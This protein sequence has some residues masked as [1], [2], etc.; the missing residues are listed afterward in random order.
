MKKMISTLWLWIAL[1]MTSGC[2]STYW[3]EDKTLVPTEFGTTNEVYSVHVGQKAFWIKS[4][5]SNLRI[6]YRGE[7]IS[8]GGYSTKG[9]AELMAEV[10]KLVVYGL[11]AYASMGSVPAIEAVLEAFKAGEVDRVISKL[12]RGETV[13]ILDFPVASSFSPSKIK[14]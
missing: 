3:E 11:S 13:T 12:E 9:D 4:D 7:T 1:C 2:V 10:S 8:L 14:K 6:P 5:I